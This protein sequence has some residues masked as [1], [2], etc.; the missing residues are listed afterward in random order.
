M[1]GCGDSL[2]A[3]EEIVM[4]YSKVTPRLPLF[5]LQLFVETCGNLL[6]YVKHLLR[7]FT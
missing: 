4:L 7:I 2:S 1:T 6:Y 5:F 3:W